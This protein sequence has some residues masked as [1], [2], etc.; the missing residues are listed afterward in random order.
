MSIKKLGYQGWNQLK[1]AG[2]GWIAEIVFSSI[3]R[4][5][6]GYLFAKFF[7]QR[8]ESGSKIMLYNKFMSI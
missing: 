2:R 7:A 6:G 5:L 8:V 1:D 3:K 4:V